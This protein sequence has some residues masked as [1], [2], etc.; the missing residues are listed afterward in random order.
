MLHYRQVCVNFLTERTGIEPA[1]VLPPA[2]FKAVSSTNRTLSRYIIPV[3]YDSR[4]NKNVSDHVTN[5]YTGANDSN[6][7]IIIF[8]SC[9]TEA[10]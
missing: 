1:K 2:A 8:C 6:P 5:K 4:Y 3:S 10:S 9:V 7:I